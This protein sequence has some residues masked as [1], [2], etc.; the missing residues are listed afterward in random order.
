M[1]MFWQRFVHWKGLQWSF[2]RVEGR[3]KKGGRDFTFAVGAELMMFR[4]TGQR[5]PSCAIICQLS[6]AAA[7]CVAQKAD[8]HKI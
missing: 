7:D 2:T 8:L 5:S 4:R 1:N 3:E 6:R